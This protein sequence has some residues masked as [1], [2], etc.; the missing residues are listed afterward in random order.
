MSE[1]RTHNYHFCEHLSPNFAITTLRSQNVSGMYGE[2]L[3]PWKA[4][5]IALYEEL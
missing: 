4:I 1:D 5:A 3:I 2:R